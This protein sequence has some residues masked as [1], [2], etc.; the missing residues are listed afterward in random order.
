MK[1][2]LGIGLIGIIILIYSFTLDPYSD[3]KIFYAKY[4][5]MNHGQ[6]DDFYRLREDM[7]TPKYRLQDI[8]ITLIIISIVTLLLMKKYNSNILTPSNKSTLTIIAFILPI[9]TITGYIFDLFQGMN[10][11]EFPRWADS[12]GIPMIGLPFQFILLMFWSLLFL[13]FIN[14]VKSFPISLSIIFKINFSILFISAITVV[15]ILVTLF[16]GQYWYCIPALLWLYYY[17]SIGIN[18]YHFKN[19]Q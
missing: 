16:Y 14:E 1:I 2:S 10:R 13:V 19:I 5:E 3:T 4:L 6:S 15:L 9:I 18:H 12:I 7:I 11:D 8:G 17:L